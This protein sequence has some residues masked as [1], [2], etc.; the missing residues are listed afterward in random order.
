MH[1]IEITV[2]FTKDNFTGS[3]TTGFV[4]VFLELIGGT[5]AKPFDVTVSP[6]EQS[7]VSAKGNNIMYIL[8]DIR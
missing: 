8:L 7:P 5:S 2:Q 6:L 1:F 4:V 3:E